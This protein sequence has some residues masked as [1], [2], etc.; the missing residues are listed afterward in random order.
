MKRS[1]IALAGILCLMLCLYV[2][3]GGCAKKAE[4]ETPAP[5][6]G[7][8]PM[9][10]MPPVAKPGEEAPKPGEIKP[11]EEAPKPG[12]VKP[13]EAPKPG[14]MKPMGPGGPKGPAMPPPPPPPPPVEGK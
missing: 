9:K 1:M 2:I 12:E 10:P 7:P 14:M 3:V 11:G 6:V 5:G 13:G 4:E 8:G